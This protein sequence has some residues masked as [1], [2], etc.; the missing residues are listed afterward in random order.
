M[1]PVPLQDVE[2]MKGAGFTVLQG[3]E[4]RTIFLGMDHKRDEPTFRSVKGKHP[5]K[6]VRAP[7]AF[8]TRLPTS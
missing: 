2:R 3:P 7:S 8:W 1:E 4:R 5:F 6:D